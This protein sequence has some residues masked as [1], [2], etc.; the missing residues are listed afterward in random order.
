MEMIT[1]KLIEKNGQ[2]NSGTTNTANEKGGISLGE[3]N[4]QNANED[5]CCSFSF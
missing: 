3:N 2:G 4:Q 1:K 5:N